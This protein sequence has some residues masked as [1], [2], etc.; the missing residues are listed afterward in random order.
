MATNSREKQRE[1]DARRGKRSRGWACVIYPES[2]PDG[3]RDALAE[4]HV[5]VLVSPLHDSDVT[6]DGT[7]KKPHWHVLAMFEAP[8]TEKAA[9]SLFAVAGVTAPPEMVRSIKA[10]AR[11]L[12]HLDDHDKHRY[13]EADV[14]E[15]CGASWGAVALDDHEERD[16]ILSEVEDWLDEQGVTSYRA[17]C[18]F[19]RAHKPEWV[20]VIRTSTIHL[21]AYVRSAEW[22]YSQREYSAQYDE[23]HAARDGEAE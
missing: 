22:E 5:Q 18:R 19:A 20:H 13:S 11:Y 14:I 2:A 21:M 8:A 9:A 6:A 15:L 1:Y 17:L 4:Q 16:R 12:V 3:W 10:Y 7:P 23:K